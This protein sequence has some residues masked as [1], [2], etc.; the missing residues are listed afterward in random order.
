MKKNIK[1]IAINDLLLDTE[2]AR[3]GGTSVENQRKAI[4]KMFK[5]KEMAKKIYNLAAHIA[6]HGL[7]PTEIPL[8]IP[9]P[10]ERG[11]PS[12]HF[13]P[14]G[15]RRILAIKL[16]HNPNLSPT[17][18][19][20]RK[21]EKLTSATVKRSLSEIQCSVVP[22]R[23]R[24]DL[25]VG[26]KHT[27]ENE[28][29]GRVN[30]DGKATDA[31]GVRTGKKKKA[32]RQILDYI[33]ADKDFSSELKAK[34]DQV[35]ITNLTR[36]FQGSPAKE[37]FGLVQKNGLLESK[38]PLSD[39]REI[40]DCVIEL[41]LE[42]DFNVKQIYLKEDQENFIK[43]KIPVTILPTA[44]SLLSDSQTW[45]LSNLDTK[46]LTKEQKQGIKSKGGAKKKPTKSMPQSQNR[47]HLI[48]FSLI[49]TNKRINKIYYELKN[50]LNVHKSPNAVAVLFRVF[51]ELTC[52]SYFAKNKI[53]RK[54]TSK[55][56]TRDDKLKVKVEHTVNYLEENRHLDK[57]QARTIRKRASAK[58]ELVSVDSLNEY[59]HAS[60]HSPIPT[61][62]N[63][64]M[65]NWA[66]FFKAIW[67]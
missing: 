59:I 35:D 25:W 41:M 54:D 31:H 65:D 26:I 50:E 22:D 17:D 45:P 52:D 44:E 57:D 55:P 38:N 40:V 28:G 19:Y 15:N 30:W 2:N 36:L 33:E 13:V 39:F 12:K 47:K 1:E 3:Y 58:N 61:E 60:G 42:D 63:I 5:I 64:L 11:K 34:V 10:G 4:E 27:G 7:D 48:D 29:V 49:V 6:K 18:S 21:I 23:G 8:V 9:I 66:P 56:L 20:R 67:K 37:A 16:L 24:A 43:E 53:K 51:L 62:L 46:T 32:G 14:E